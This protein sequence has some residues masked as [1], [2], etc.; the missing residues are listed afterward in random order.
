MEPRM[1]L[2]TTWSGREHGQSAPVPMVPRAPRQAPAVGRAPGDGERITRASGAAGSCLSQ[3]PSWPTGAWQ[4]GPLE[5]GSWPHLP[6]PLLAHWSLAAGITSQ[7]PCPPTPD[8]CP[9]SSDGS[10]W[11]GGAG[12]PGSCLASARPSRDGEPPC[13][14]HRTGGLLRLWTTLVQSSFLDGNEISAPTTYRSDP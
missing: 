10:M 13:S 14:P 5:P 9:C 6:E 4:A 1:C 3:S 11:S 7:S 12:T 8:R 2:R